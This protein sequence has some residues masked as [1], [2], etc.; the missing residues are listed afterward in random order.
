MAVTRTKNTIH[1]TANNDAVAGQFK[2]LSIVYS[3]T[4]AGNTITIEDGYT[5]EGEILFKGVLS[6]N[7]ETL[8]ISGPAFTSP[9]GF[10]VTSMPTGFVTVYHE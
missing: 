3:G 2:I 1:M 5:A 8:Q 6:V 7:N 4:T 9:T 10:K